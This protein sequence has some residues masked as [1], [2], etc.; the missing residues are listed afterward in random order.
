MLGVVSPLVDGVPATPPGGLSL[1]RAPG[2]S[3]LDYSQTLPLL[4]PAM[5]GGWTSLV[6]RE[7][8]G[9]AGFTTAGREML[10]LGQ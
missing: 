10:A 8:G 9:G 2:N 3:F 7:A 1:R 5:L 4:P 6:S